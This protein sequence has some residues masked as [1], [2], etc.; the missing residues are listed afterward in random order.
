MSA[1]WTWLIGPDGGLAVINLVIAWVDLVLGIAFIYLLRRRRARTHAMRPHIHTATAVLVML[2]LATA[3]ST[4]GHWMPD[5]T[6]WM[7]RV[8]LV[9]LRSGILIALAAWLM[10]MSSVPVPRWA[11]RGLHSHHQG[12]VH[13]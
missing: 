9:A 11:M 1:E 3:I 10:A 4:S 2:L 8:A 7:A 12:G 13:R 5:G 6:Q